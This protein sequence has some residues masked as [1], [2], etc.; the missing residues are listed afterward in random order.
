MQDDPTPDLDALLARIA[1]CRLC[2]DAP[3][4]AP[5]PH[6]PR[7]VVRFSSTARL[8]IAGQAPGVRVHRSGLPFDDPSGERL[9]DWMGIDRAT[10]YDTARIAIAPMGFCFPGLDAKGSDLPPRPEERPS[11]PV[12]ITPY[13]YMAEA[14]GTLSAAPPPG[15]PAWRPCSAAWPS[16]WPSWGALQL[17]SSSPRPVSMA[18]ASIR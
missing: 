11:Q 18:W 17:P 12:L 4:G 5:L 8:L 10:F 13:K 7:P 15:P 2:R 3:R 9:R 14:A 6:E 16:C 1:A